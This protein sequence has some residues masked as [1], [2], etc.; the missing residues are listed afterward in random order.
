MENT[1]K[2]TVAGIL[3]IISGVSNLI[4]FVFMIFFIIAVNSS[5]VFVL[6]FIPEE[7]LPFGAGLIVTIIALIATLLA[8]QG[9]LPLIGGIYALQRRKWLFTLISSIVAIFGATPLGIAST[10]LVAVAKEEFV[11]TGS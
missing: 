11:N 3:N 5:S 10:I 7:V 4:G 6:R 8:I 2:P 9:I 1:W